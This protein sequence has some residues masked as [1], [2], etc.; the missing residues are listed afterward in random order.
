MIKGK[1]KSLIQFNVLFILIGIGAIYIGYDA[2]LVAKDSEVWTAIDGTVIASWIDEVEFTGSEP[3]QDASVTLVADET[4]YFPH[5]IYNFTVNSQLYIGNSFYAGGVNSAR[6]TIAEADEIIAPHSPGAVITIYYD[7]NNPDNN[8]VFK[9][10]H[11]EHYV[12]QFIGL[13]FLGWGVI[14]ISVIIL[15]SLIRRIIKLLRRKKCKR[16][17]KLNPQKEFYCNECGKKF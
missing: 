4:S 7:V 13:A 17:G 11:L 1:H 6:E 10:V 16:C 15:I 2:Y 14:S 9:G 12:F 5:I 3:N 8:A